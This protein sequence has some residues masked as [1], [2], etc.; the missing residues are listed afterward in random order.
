M[1]FFGVDLPHTRKIA[2]MAVMTALCAVVNMFSIDIAGVFK[3]SFVTAV[4][5]ISA[6][7]F[8]PIL[9][10][11]IAFLGDLIGFLLVPSPYAYSPYIG[12]CNVLFTVIV[13]VF[14]MTLTKRIGFVWTSVI[15]L[16][17]AHVIAS[18]FLNS[19]IVSSLYSS[20]GFWVILSQRL[21][22]QT[23]VNAFNGLLAVLVVK[24]MSKISFLKLPK[25]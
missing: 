1:E 5:M 23:P 13:A 20:S 24:G 21:L 10:G 4:C 14:Y 16:F 12:L 18:V 15:A 22:L 7:L 8:G 6:Y 11:V 9:G 3:L 17:V 19:Y 2:Y 25:V